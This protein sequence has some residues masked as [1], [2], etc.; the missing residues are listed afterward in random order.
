MKNPSITPVKVLISTFLLSLSAQV[1][2]ADEVIEFERTEWSRPYA[3]VSCRSARET[4]SSYTSKSTTRYQSYLTPL[5]IKSLI[6][7]RSYME[8]E[9]LI[10]QTNVK[11]Y[12]EHA[13]A[14][15]KSAEIMVNFSTRDGE[16][17][18]STMFYWSTDELMHLEDQKSDNFSVNDL[19]HTQCEAKGAAQRYNTC[20]F[21]ASADVS[22]QLNDMITTL[23]QH[24][25]NYPREP[26]VIEVS[27]RQE[28]Y[29]DCV[30][31]RSVAYARGMNQEPVLILRD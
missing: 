7:Q 12:G 31:K 22:E 5:Q 9:R 20:T 16:E 17:L 28:L 26:V 30:G 3:K 23:K 21:N 15:L 4:S 1:G 8:F 29:T 2:Y 18:L 27:Y 10:T 14:S 13:Y 25:L 19:G 11:A 6:S 24:Y